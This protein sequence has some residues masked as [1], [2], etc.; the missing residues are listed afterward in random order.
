MDNKDAFA[1]AGPTAFFFENEVIDRLF[2]MNLALAAEISAV[3]EKLDTVLRLLERQ[4]VLEPTAVAQFEPSEAEQ[5]AR[6]AVRKTFV[7]T[8]LAPFQHQAD[9]L[10]KQA[11]AMRA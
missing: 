10:G 8:L 2:G 3:S 9:D 6:D 4:Q 7:S 11:A 5:A 1:V